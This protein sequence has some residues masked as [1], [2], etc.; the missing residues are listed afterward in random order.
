MTQSTSKPVIQPTGL[1][2]LH[3]HLVPGVDD[4]SASE[5]ESF[6]MLQMAEADGIHS[7]VATPHIFSKLNTEK[8]MESLF[9]ASEEFLEK[10]KLFDFHIKV[11]PG[12]EVFFTTNLRTYFKEYQ[13]LLTLNGSSYF[14]LEFPFDFIFPG[15][16]EFIY[17]IQMDGWI[18]IIAHPERNQVIQRNPRILFEMVQQGALCQVN[19]GSLLGHFG[20]ATRTTAFLL[21]Q[22]NLVHVIASDAHS[23]KHRPPQLSSA[24]KLLKENNADIADML[25]IKIPQAVLRDEAIPDIGDPVDPCKKVKFFDFIFRRKT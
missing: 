4:G 12:A 6:M 10:V 24:Y 9:K 1:I 15:V 3:A 25:L 14:I 22:Y 13:K 16:K 8:D 19:T 21:I 11:F 18:P 7:I 17:D 20:G 5:K 2:D 23:I